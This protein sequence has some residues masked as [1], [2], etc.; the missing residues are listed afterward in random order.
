MAVM[1][2]HKVPDRCKLVLGWYV[3]RKSA[4]WQL[5][6]RLAGHAVGNALLV[7]QQVAEQGLLHSELGQATL[8]TSS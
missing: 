3:G 4:T 5:H 6:W 8:A 2:D 1:A 7:L